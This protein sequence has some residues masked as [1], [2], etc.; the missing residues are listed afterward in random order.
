VVKGFAG[1][2][3]A[4]LVGALFL[5]M[6]DAAAADPSLKVEEEFLGAT[7]LFLGEPTDVY[8]IVGEA[9]GYLPNTQLTISVSPALGIPSWTII[10]TSVRTDA[11]GDAKF[12][13][14]HGEFGITVEPVPITPGAPA[15][16]VAINTRDIVNNTL[17]DRP[18][19]LAVCD[20]QNCAGV[21]IPQTPGPRI[22]QNA[23]PR[24]V[25]RVFSTYNF[26]HAVQ[27]GGQLLHREVCGFEKTFFDGLVRAPVGFPL[28]LIPG[29]QQVHALGFDPL[30]PFVAAQCSLDPEAL[31]RQIK[32]VQ[33]VTSP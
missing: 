31:L 9:T 30:E 14:R 32:R 5:L 22:A 26:F 4:V 13:F 16:L 29:A 18:W 6:P 33:G 19:N 25:D 20:T 27:T 28:F 12:S 10:D 11:R 8:Q 7:V 2:A 3:A 21:R 24:P 1:L 15:P 17:V 23:P